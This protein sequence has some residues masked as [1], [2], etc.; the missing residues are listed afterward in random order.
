MYSF[1]FIHTAGSS[2][3]V[4]GGEQGR[5][6]CQGLKRETSELFCFL[7]QECHY[8]EHSTVVLIKHRSASRRNS[9]TSA[10]PPHPLAISCIHIIKWNDG[11]KQREWR[12]EVATNCNHHMILWS[13]D[14]VEQLFSGQTL[15]AK[16]NCNAQQRRNGSFTFI[17]I[18]LRKI[19]PK[20]KWQCWCPFR[21]KHFPIVRMMLLCAT[22]SPP[23]L[24]TVS[25][26][27]LLGGDWWHGGHVALPM[28]LASPAPGTITPHRHCA[29]ARAPP[30]LR[31]AR[32]CPGHCW[33]PSPLHTDDLWLVPRSDGRGV[34]RR[35]DGRMRRVTRDSW[36]HECHKCIQADLISLHLSSRNLATSKL[37][38]TSIRYLT[39]SPE[40]NLS[41]TPVCEPKCSN[42][43]HFYAPQL[44]YQHFN[45][46]ITFWPLLYYHHITCWQ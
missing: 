1:W 12:W 37:S 7:A 4:A 44:G 25:D 2:R 8:A 32:S 14:P 30:S 31:W 13:T 22:W 3:R 27:V 26:W 17:K 35:Y 9:V 18:V 45:N 23:P 11:L 38:S 28:T 5:Y 24:L 16:I 39:L 20:L 29:R 21:F 42:E 46:V 36:C 19:P 10:H 34:R 33:P 43:N 15:S 41:R 6:H 40:P